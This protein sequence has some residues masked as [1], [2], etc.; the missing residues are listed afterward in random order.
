MYSLIY[1]R[2]FK[3]DVRLLKKRGYDMTI[4]KNAILALEKKGELEKQFLPHKL[5]GKLSDYWEA[6]LKPDWL[7]I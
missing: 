2:K 3:K 4:L 1:S 7:I 5:S 6:H